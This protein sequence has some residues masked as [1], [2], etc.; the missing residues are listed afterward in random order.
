MR[1]LLFGGLAVLVI[2]PCCHAQAVA[3]PPPPL[4][5]ETSQSV[6]A[7]PRH[8][9]R[10]RE[11]IDPA[12][13]KWKVARGT[14]DAPSARVLLLQNDS[15]TSAPSWGALVD[16]WSFRAP[17]GW[18]ANRVLGT[19]I[20]IRQVPA[21]ER[22][23]SLAFVP[24]GSA[25]NS[26]IPSLSAPALGP[27]SLATDV[28][29]LSDENDV[30][31]LTSNSTGFSL[32][33]GTEDF[34]IGLN[35]KTSGMRQTQQSSNHA[36]L[37]VSYS[38]LRTTET[39]LNPELTDAAQS[40]WQSDPE[41]FFGKYGTHYISSMTTGAQLKVVYTFSAD[42]RTTLSGFA[43]KAGLSVGFSGWNAGLSHSINNAMQDYSATV[44]VSSHVVATGKAGLGQPGT[45]ALDFDAVKTMVDNYVGRLADTNQE[46]LP[47]LG[48]RLSNYA[49]LFRGIP[50]GSQRAIAHAVNALDE[51]S[52]TIDDVS[53]ILSYPT[54][55]GT[56]LPIQTLGAL[57]LRNGQ[58]TDAL[59]KVL[60]FGDAASSGVLETLVLD[61]LTYRNGLNWP[62]TPD[63]P[64]I[65]WPAPPPIVAATTTTPTPTP[66][67]NTTPDLFAFAIEFPMDGPTK[68][69]SA[70]LFIENSASA[71]ATPPAT[72]PPIPGPRDLHILAQFVDPTRSLL[73]YNLE[74]VSIPKEEK[75]TTWVELVDSAG[76]TFQFYLATP[77]GQRRSDLA[78]SGSATM[79]YR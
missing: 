75:R 62:K 59:T 24:Q 20:D 50:P 21:F 46:G 56:K 8:S 54:L 52:D 13:Q 41:A 49:E 7:G 15:S 3:P 11:W 61:W 44:R 48:F 78:S 68:L 64:T 47:V 45:V 71:P 27:I 25:S 19:G 63:G 55:Y 14:L 69:Q 33:F 73:I 2:A 58:I 74:P 76:R 70:R 36:W 26:L 51:I 22:K 17:Q 9:T 57:N 18:D 42:S 65:Q 72:A 29:F 4:L 30:A 1:R 67:T 31:K 28:Q 12:S 34:S 23:R 60:E 32:G 16:S 38:D 10:A 53:L 77:D 37:V 6:K 43:T 79:I 5:F 66:T 39:R 40:T 35:F